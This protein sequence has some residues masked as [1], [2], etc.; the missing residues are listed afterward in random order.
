MVR[1]HEGS[2]RGDDVDGF[3]ICG[4]KARMTG[5]STDRADRKEK[6]YGRGK[7]ELESENLEKASGD[8]GPMIQMPGPCPKCGSNNATYKITQQFKTISCSACGYYEMIKMG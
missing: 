4:C 2:N 3:A 7:K 6:W 5:K 8:V 1:F